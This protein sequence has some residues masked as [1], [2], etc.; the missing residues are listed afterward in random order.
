MRKVY[1]WIIGGVI[2]LATAFLSMG[3]AAVSDTLFVQGE[4]VLSAPAYD[5]YISNIT[6]TSSGGTDVTGYFSTIMSATVTGQTSSTFTVTVVNQSIRDYLFDR[7]I[8]GEELEIDG[9]YTGEDITYQLS[10]IKKGDE[11]LPNG[12]TLTFDIT[13]H[14]PAGVSTDYFLLKFNFIERF[15]A[16]GEEEFPEEMPEGEVS[17]VQRLSDILN[18]IYTTN[19]VTNARDYLINETIQVRWDEWAPP[20][21]GSMDDDYY[22]QINELFGDI[23]DDMHVSFILKNQDINWD[24]FSEIALY[25]TSDT[26]DNT[27][28]WGSNGVVCVYVTVFTPVIDSSWN[29]IGYNLVCESVRGYCYEVRY[30]TND[31]TPS[32][33]TDEWRTDV[34]Y[35]ESW[36]SVENK[37][38]LKPIPD[39]TLSN[40]GTKL[41]K[42]DYDSYNLYYQ[43]YKTAPY[44]DT[45]NV[46]LDD[47]IPNLWET[48]Q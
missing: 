7:V 24:G 23:I 35:M 25:S 14:A 9:A 47:K 30:G 34:G 5:V 41:Y 46:F 48:N 21:V 20:Y 15:L 8:E 32:F 26:L 4:A 22:V 3:Y 40:D 17:L 39:D 2:A 16:P 12:G 19:R 27:D 10:G 43:W 44:G 28:A 36:D 6:P 38:I 31:L 11:I 13:I 42:L 45:I 37:P 1:Q 33:S 18:N 29:I